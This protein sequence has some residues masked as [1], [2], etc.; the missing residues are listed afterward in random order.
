[1]A[2]GKEPSLRIED[3]DYDLPPELIAQH[4]APARELSRLLVLDRCAG[5]AHHSRFDKIGEYLR[6]GDLLVVNDTRVVPA[7]LVGRKK[8][9]GRVEFL[10]LDP[11][12]PPELG[13]TE[14]YCCLTKASKPVRTGQIVEF[15]E[16]ICAEVVSAPMDGK[17]RVRFPGASNIVDVLDRIGRTPLPPYIE[18]EAAE[19]SEA[20]LICYQT[21]YARQPG[22][23]AAPTAG[24]HF[25]KSLLNDLAASGIEVAALTLHVGYGT[26][27]PVRCEDIREHRMHAE[28][29]EIGEQTANT[30]NRAKREHRRVVAVGTTVVRTLEWVFA[31]RGELTPFRGMCD[32]FIYPGYRF[33]VVD[34]LVTNFH[35]PKS[36][37]ILLVSALAGR[38][39]ILSAYRE[40]VRERYR[41]FSY[42]DAMLIL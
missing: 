11:Y 34:S 2:D 25:T 16:G 42:G 24:L 31:K 28:F 41:F 7:R 29:I 35:V 1:M 23:V 38:R 37:L 30:V 3:Y 13:E 26:F 4:P 14:G 10:V 17:V 19:P 27:S 36:S 40:A 8:T 9:G 18:R 6:P 21:E 39:L 22:A 20:D 33:A 12:K 15:A 32:H 5:A